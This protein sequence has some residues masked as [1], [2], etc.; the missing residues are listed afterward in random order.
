M[1]KRTFGSTS[2]GQ[3]LFPMD[4]ATWRKVSVSLALSPQQLRIVELILQGQQ[5]KEI[6]SELGL[7]VPTVRTYLK[8]IFD[9]TGVADRLALVLHV[10]AIAQKLATKQSRHQQ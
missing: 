8:R 6:A 5:D 1:H 4:K 9:R 3:T 10:F 7:S 2:T